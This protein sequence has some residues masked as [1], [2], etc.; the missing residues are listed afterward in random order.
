MNAEK[1]NLMQNHFSLEQSTAQIKNY[2]SLMQGNLYQLYL[3]NV[4][5]NFSEFEFQLL[6]KH[7]KRVIAKAIANKNKSYIELSKTVEI[8]N[9]RKILLRRYLSTLLQCDRKNIYNWID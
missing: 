6:C 3:S 8:K 2:I 1:I 4:N 7:T 5:A 9:K